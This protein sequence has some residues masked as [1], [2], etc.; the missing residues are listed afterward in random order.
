MMEH[1]I[2][3]P[4]PHGRRA[5]GRSPCLERARRPAGTSGLTACDRFPLETPRVTCLYR[6]D[7]LRPLGQTRGRRMEIASIDRVSVGR[8]RSSPGVPTRF[9]LR[10]RLTSRD[11]RR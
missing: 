2:A 3:T 8:A 9:A 6:V 11:N 5:R 4:P 1:A 7:T 10:T